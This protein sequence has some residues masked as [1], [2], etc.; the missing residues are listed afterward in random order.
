[1]SGVR[2]SRGQVAA[3]ESD[4]AL[5]IPKVLD[6]PWLDRL[7]AATE[8][9]LATSDNYF[10]R[11]RVWQHEADFAEFCLRSDAPRL[12]AQLLATDR[13]NLLYDQVF[14]KEP[15]TATRTPWHNDQPYWPVRGW[16]VMTLWFALDPITASNGALELIPRLASLGSLVPTVSGRHRWIR[17]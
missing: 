3:F 8:R 15:G 14:V 1:M 5:L 4:G 16:P 9:A 10:R 2:L 7:R 17:R 6:D 13:I 11:L 12:A